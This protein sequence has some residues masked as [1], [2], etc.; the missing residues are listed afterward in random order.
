MPL[1]QRLAVA[2][3]PAVPVIILFGLQRIDDFFSGYYLFYGVSFGAFVL[4]PYA[5]RD[6]HTTKRVIALTITPVLLLAL[7]VQGLLRGW[8]WMDLVYLSFVIYFAVLAI[9]LGTAVKFAAPL[10]TNFRYWLFV[11][12]SG[13]ITGI[14]FGFWLVR[15]FDCMFSSCPAENDWLFVIALVFWHESFCAAIHFGRTT[16]L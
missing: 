4:A 8:V 14:C 5:S 3:L 1:Y 13:S 6:S 12:L 9:T 16:E 2:S 11:F 10:R 15:M 7:L